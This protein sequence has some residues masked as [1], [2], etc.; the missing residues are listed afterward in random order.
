MHFTAG[1]IL[2]SYSVDGFFLI[3][4]DVMFNV[5]PPGDGSEERSR[6]SQRSSEDVVS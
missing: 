2:F 3:L 6:I 4:G 5:G 1:F